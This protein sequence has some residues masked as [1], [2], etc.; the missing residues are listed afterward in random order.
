MASMDRDI[1]AL[2]QWIGACTGVPFTAPLAQELKVPGS[3][4]RVCVSML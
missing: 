4:G 3:E 2:E 1:A